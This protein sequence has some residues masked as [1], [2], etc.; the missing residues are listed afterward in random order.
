M[1]RG[2]GR[3]HKQITYF[4]PSFKRD[5]RALGTQMDSQK[6]WILWRGPALDSVCA[7]EKP[8]TTSQED[9][10]CTRG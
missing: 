2:I 6:I 10:R 4:L 3:E 8:V 9:G 5:E 7:G 1:G